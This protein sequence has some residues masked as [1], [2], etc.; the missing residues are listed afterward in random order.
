MIDK[1]I[2]IPNVSAV[3]SATKA[4]GVNIGEQFNSMLNDAIAKIDGDHKEVDKLNNMFA[5]GELPDVHKLL[6]ESQKAELNLQLTVQ[7]RNKVIEA[8]QEIMR[9]QV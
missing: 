9:T 6:I 2:G 4:S 5:A 3:N 1:V 8:Y 7:I